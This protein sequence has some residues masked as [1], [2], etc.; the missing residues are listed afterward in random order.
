[1]RRSILLAALSAVFTLA[2][3][4]VAMAQ[5]V[6]TPRDSSVDCS[7]AEEGQPP[8]IEFYFVPDAGG[9]IAKGYEGGGT[10][11][12]VLYDFSKV[13]F[14]PDTG[15]RLG[16]VR[17]LDPDLSSGANSL[18]H[19]EFCGSFDGLPE[20]ALTAQEY[21]EQ[22]SDAEAQA[23]LDPDGDGLACTQELKYVALGDSFS[24]GEGVPPFISGKDGKEI[25]CHR[26]TR[27][28]AKLLD[29]DPDL[30][31]DLQAFE[32]CSGATTWEVIENQL[33]AVTEDTDLVTVTIGGNDVGFSWFVTQCLEPKEISLAF[34]GESCEKG[35]TPYADITA[36]ISRLHNG[37]G[38]V[39][40]KI[41]DEIGPNTKVLVV[42]YPFV[43][44]ERLFAGRLGLTCSAT[45]PSGL[46][47]LTGA[48]GPALL[49][50]LPLLN[51]V[52][53]LLNR[54][55][56]RAAVDITLA[57]N[58]AIGDA[59]T[60]TGDDRFHYVSAAGNP[61]FRG[62]DMC[63]GQPY[64]ND[65]DL[66]HK[67]YTAHPNKK[68]QATY[69][70]LIKDYWLSINKNQQ[71]DGVCAGI[72]N[73]EQV[74]RAD[75]DGDGRLD[76]VALVG[77][78]NKY[79]SG[80]NTQITVR[81]LLADGT[82]LT[83][84]AALE[85]WFGDTAWLGATDFGQI[86]G[87][88]LV[89]AG[90][91]GPHTKWY[92]VLTYRD[93]DL[94]ELPRPGRSDTFYATMWPVD[95]AL[96]AYVGVQ[97]ETTSS[98][99]VLRSVTPPGLP[100]ADSTYEGK[101]TSWVLDGDQWRMTGSRELMYPDGSSASEIAGW[102]CGDLPRV[103]G[104]GGDTNPSGGSG[105]SI[106][107]GSTSP[108]QD[109]GKVNLDQAVGDYYRAAGAQ[110]WSYTYDHLGS[111]TQSMFTEEEWY[112]RNQWF[113]DRNAIVYHILST[114]VVGSSGE[115]P[116]GEVELRITPEYDSSWTRTTYFVKEGGEWLHRFSQEETDLFMPDAT[117]E[118]FV[119]AQA[120]PPR[121]F[122]P[123]PPPT[124]YG[125]RFVRCCP[126][127]DAPTLLGIR[128]SPRRRLGLPVERERSG[129]YRGGLK[130]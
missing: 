29:Q 60:A 82:T 92:R 112:R 13:V 38:Y 113:W 50:V 86:P 45:V 42:G 75:V 9:C 39:L 72:P 71:K 89:I 41:Q 116:I 15:E 57:L 16:T 80:P 102:Q 111:Q 2:F 21:F 48:P 76:D 126:W 83:R 22:V 81:V 124:A 67:D 53:P 99:V 7:A 52:L 56:Q 63:S 101:A 129:L 130:P 118:E 51:S 128:G 20:R 4:S 27:A 95:A 33:S 36:N 62:H 73:C 122:L 100:S 88:E 103:Y 97:C 127:H 90:T 110:E 32:A 85:A 49:T 93:G 1:M 58:A 117:F 105:D 69:A 24:S 12:P 106:R 43:V 3:A 14:D 46:L 66:V 68:G 98:T 35:K 5:S 125:G 37:L 87:E 109:S 11:N 74:D 31:F 28:Y 120:E 65:L 34:G 107:G 94:V 121:R 10:P 18:T 6:Y 55:E 17:E 30:N 61:P 123:N 8:G 44:E 77:E 23:I 84:E 114:N 115:P 91:S 47:L 26:S 59:V 79:P 119:K 40:G 64:F 19:Q 104:T 108:P 96:S 70:K 25:V 54:A 78:A